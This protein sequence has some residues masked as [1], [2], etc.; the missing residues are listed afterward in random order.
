M[1]AA[2]LEEEH[3]DA[4]TLARAIIVALDDKRRADP[5]YVLGA[6]YEGL[7]LLW[8]PYST[9]NQAARAAGKLVSPYK[10]R[11][12]ACR[13]LRVWQVTDTPDAL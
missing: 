5:V 7:P 12:L 1:V 4:P 6:M 9:G 11:S 13:V 8:G 10:E 3:P 2:M